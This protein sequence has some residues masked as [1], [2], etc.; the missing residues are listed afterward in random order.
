MFDG[1]I[2]EHTGSREF[3]DTPFTF[4]KIKN[5][6]GHIEEVGL[7]TDHE[8]PV[9]TRITGTLHHAGFGKTSDA[10][11]VMLID[12]IR[13]MKTHMPVMIERGL[14]E[15][16]EEGQ[17]GIDFHARQGRNIVQ[18][19]KDH[20]IGRWINGVITRHRPSFPPSS[21]LE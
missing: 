2:V 3:A 7:V 11:H 12:K 21:N 15:L 14:Q 8:I 1:T 20:P 13:V 4:V 6:K 17:R 16:A 9:G 10:P 19:D 18:E 5:T